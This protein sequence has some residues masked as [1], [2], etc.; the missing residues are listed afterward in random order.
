LAFFAKCKADWLCECE[1]KK[2]GRFYAGV[3][4]LYIGGCGRHLADDQDLEFDVP[5]P[6]DSAAGEVVHE[7]LDEAEKEF[8]AEHLKTLRNVSTILNIQKLTGLTCLVSE[9]GCGTG[10][11]MGTF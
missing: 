3:A 1:A 9:S 8:R 6:E 2:S 4:G 5:D 7:V 11:R 10:A